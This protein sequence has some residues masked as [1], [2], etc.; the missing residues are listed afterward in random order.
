M[1]GQLRLNSSSF[2]YEPTAPTFEYGNET[3]GSTECGEFLN[4]LGK[5]HLLN[6]TYSL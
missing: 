3:T 1:I 2:G 6:K 4:W 5:Y